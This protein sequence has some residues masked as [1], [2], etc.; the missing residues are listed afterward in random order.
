MSSESKQGEGKESTEDNES[1]ETSS[2][3]DGLSNLITAFLEFSYSTDLANTGKLLL[4]EMLF[5]FGLTLPPSFPNRRNKRN[6]RI[7]RGI[8]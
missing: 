7:K 5:W 2:D 4:K 6:H 1:K 3:L 8:N